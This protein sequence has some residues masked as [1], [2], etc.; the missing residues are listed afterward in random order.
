MIREASRT[1]ARIRY[2]R[3]HN[4]PGFGFAVRAGL[5]VYEGDAAVI[6][7]ADGSDSPHDIAT[8]YGVLSE[9][10]DCAFGSRFVRGSRVIDYPKPKLALNRDGV[11]LS[12]LWY[13]GLTATFLLIIYSLANIP[14]AD[15]GLRILRSA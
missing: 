6:V 10:Y 11:I 2:H 8:Y 15:L 9:G 12:V 13:A 14:G 7:M 4:P 3:S 5:D 1:N